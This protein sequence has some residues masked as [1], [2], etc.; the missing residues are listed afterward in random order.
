MQLAVLYG[1]RMLGGPN[2]P[3][4]IDSVRRY[5]TAEVSSP[6]TVSA[7]RRQVSRAV[8]TTDIY[9]VDARGQ[10]LAELIGVHNHAM[11]QA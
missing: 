10:R 3:T 6:I 9:V 5:A 7:H 11:M 4:A 2:L 8:V 1:R